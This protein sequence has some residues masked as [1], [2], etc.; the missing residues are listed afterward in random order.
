MNETSTVSFAVRWGMAAALLAGFATLGGCPGPTPMA[1][2][3]GAGG[4]GSTSETSSS[5]SSSTSSTSS[6]SSSGMPCTIASDCPAPSKECKVA[7]CTEGICGFDFK[8]A[9]TA[10]TENG[11]KL[12]D[13]AGQCVSCLSEKECP[14][15]DSAC[16]VPVCA[17]GACDVKPAVASTPCQ[18]N[19]GKVC[20]GAGKCVL[21]AES[22]DCADPTATLC[23][24]NFYTPQ[25]TCVGGV[26]V[27]GVKTDCLASKLVCTSMGCDACSA[28]IQCGI[29]PVGACKFPKCQSGSCEAGHQAQGT[30]C[31]TANGGGSCNGG[32]V[33]TAGKY[34][35]VTTAVLPPT[36]GGTAAADAKCQEI[37]MNAGLA[38][39]WL[40]WTSDSK[41]KPP[42][43][44]FTQSALPYRLL[45]DTVVASS[46]A[47]LTSGTLAHAINMAEDHSVL[48][49]NVEV[50][51]GTNTAGLH[52][53]A[54]CADWLGGPASVGG[55][56]AGLA[57]ATNGGW[58]KALAKQCDNNQVA[59]LYCFQQ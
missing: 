53:G 27:A 28:D 12:C 16:V 21:C 10:C 4:G 42:A 37:A 43:E 35:F 23:E 48:P 45:D 22:S 5:S 7:I 54:S 24:G 29:A 44:R 50:W 51:T 13:G 56:Y 26:C 18:D 52:G 30:A 36:F 33:C 17:G 2:P 40:S 41:T 11:G 3:G 49:Q 34:V 58:T 14:V 1:G 59:H 32:G 31:T 6:S 46:W 57:G 8:P 20:D 25:P 55:G 38:G 47:G 39:T 15:T 19:G 9:M